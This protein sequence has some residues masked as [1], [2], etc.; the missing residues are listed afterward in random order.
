MSA[1]DEAIAVGRAGACLDACVQAMPW[2]KERIESV[3]AKVCF[4]RVLVFDACLL[5]VVVCCCV[6]RAVVIERTEKSV[7]TYV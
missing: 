6:G 7:Q 5:C 1:F 4:K 3:S 2:V